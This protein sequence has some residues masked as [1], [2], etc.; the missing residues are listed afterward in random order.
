M[1]RSQRLSRVEN[2]RLWRRVHSVVKSCGIAFIATIAGMYG[3]WLPAEAKG[4]LS[5]LINRTNK[6]T[7]TRSVVSSSTPLIIEEGVGSWYGPRFHGRRTASGE[8]YD[9]HDYTAA[10]LT[11]PFGTIL[12]VTNTEN[13]RS[14]LVRVNDRGPY[15]QGRLI[16]LSYSAAKDLGVHAPGTGALKLEVYKMPESD[17]TGFIN[18]LGMLELPVD[19]TLIPFVEPSEMLE[20]GA[21]TLAFDHTMA[22]VKINPSHAK[23]IHETDCL[24]HAMNAWKKLSRKH[25]NLVLVADTNNEFGAQAARAK[26]AKR[27]FRTPQ[28]YTP[29]IVPMYQ[30]RLAEVQPVR[31]FALQ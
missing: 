3:S 16:D 7:A 19:S 14:T 26:N 27:K 21:N 4:F 25:P 24:R 17:L 12:R 13:G 2:F 10:H 11:L 28:R 5:D 31:A 30:Y 15:I 29:E 18:S 9:M 1:K 23:I 6:T 22:P 20:S 8:I